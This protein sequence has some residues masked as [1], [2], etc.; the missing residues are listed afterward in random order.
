[1]PT[2]AGRGCSYQATQGPKLFRIN[3]ILWHLLPN[4]A[5]TDHHVARRGCSYQDTQGP[6]LFRIN[7]IL[8]HLLPTRALTDHHVARK[9]V[10]ISR[11]PRSKFLLPTAF[12]LP[13]RFIHL[14]DVAHAEGLGQCGNTAS[15][16]TWPA[17]QAEAQGRMT[18]AGKV[19]RPSKAAQPPTRA[20]CCSC[21]RMHTSVFLWPRFP[22]VSSRGCHPHFLAM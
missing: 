5:L 14:W 12:G 4:R 13:H 2:R 21:E 15:L 16:D 9:G 10:L 17:I 22:G 11:H 1:M 7:Q 20:G 6:K 8:W 18:R 19:G 3:Q